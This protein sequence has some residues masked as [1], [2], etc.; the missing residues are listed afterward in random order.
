LADA[1]VVNDDVDR[2]AREVQGI[3]QRFREAG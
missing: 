3:L 1:V 2:A